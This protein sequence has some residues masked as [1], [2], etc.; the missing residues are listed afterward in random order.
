MFSICWW[1]IHILQ[2]LLKCGSYFFAI[3]VR[4]FSI[5]AF[6][7]T[8]EM[9]NLVSTG[10]RPPYETFSWF[11]IFKLSFHI[12]GTLV[13]SKSFVKLFVAKAFHED[14]GTI[15]S[16][17]MLVDPQA[18]FAMF[19]LC[20]APTLWLLTLYNHYQKMCLSSLW[21]SLDLE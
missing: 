13:R 18:T 8:N 9:C 21:V 2:V 4:V 1:M 16:L 20:Y 17:P 15:S 14:F 6:N 10:V 11:F 5:K 19:S 3:I 7:A 12:L